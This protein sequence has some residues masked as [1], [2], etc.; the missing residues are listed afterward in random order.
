MLKEAADHFE[1]FKPTGPVKRSLSQLHPPPYNKH[2]INYCYTKHPSSQT[3]NTAT[4]HAHH[5]YNKHYLD[6]SNDT[7]NYH[8]TDIS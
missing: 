4:I 2:N 7:F 8:T 1:M 6:H 5:G 3:H